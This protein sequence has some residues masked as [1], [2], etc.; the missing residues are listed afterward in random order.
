MYPYKTM[1]P[2]LRRRVWTWILPSQGSCSS[3]NAQLGGSYRQVWPLRSG[4]CVLERD[5]SI[6]KGGV[7]PLLSSYRAQY[8]TGVWTWVQGSLPQRFPFSV[9]A[10]GLN[11]PYSLLLKQ[12]VVFSE[13]S[14]AFPRFMQGAASL[15]LR[16]CLLS[17]S[18]CTP[19]NGNS[20]WSCGVLRGGHR[21]QSVLPALERAHGPAAMVMEL[22]VPESASSSLPSSPPS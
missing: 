6:L 19:G 5:C 4:R 3:C 10:P 2:G 11:S 13:G 12:E 15:C 9:R 18:F 16:L 22:G 17:S 21:G 14:V 8:Q 20:T 1:P 7:P